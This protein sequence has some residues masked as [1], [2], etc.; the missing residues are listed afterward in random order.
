MKIIW[1]I[2]ISSSVV[3]NQV[4]LCQKTNSDSQ[5]PAVVSPPALPSTLS[6][7]SLTSVSY[8]SSILVTPSHRLEDRERERGRARGRASLS[9][10]LL[11]LLLCCRSSSSRSH[12]SSMPTGCRR[13]A[14]QQRA[15]RVLPLLLSPRLSSPPHPPPPLPIFSHLSSWIFSSSFSFHPAPQLQDVALGGSAPL[16][17]LCSDPRWVCLHLLSICSEK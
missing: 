5:I 15:E 8:V 3:S 11:L 9:L 17:I 12:S 4:N 14:F 2:G 1:L 16:W 6:T 10:L 13:R 7:P